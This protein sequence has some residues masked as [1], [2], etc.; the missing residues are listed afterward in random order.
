MPAAAPWNG[1][2][3]CKSLFHSCRPSN[4]NPPTII[5]L[6]PLDQ[7]S[8]VSTIRPDD[9]K[10]V[11]IFLHALQ[12]QLGAVAVL[13]IRRLDDDELEDQPQCIDQQVPFPART[14]LPNFRP[15][16]GQGLLAGREKRRRIV[17]DRSVGG[18]L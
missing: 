9:F 13:D 15:S 3:Q 17:L 2:W 10:L 8:R 18:A 14:T 6:R 12:H 16:L 11:K 5:A 1:S 7:L 4:P